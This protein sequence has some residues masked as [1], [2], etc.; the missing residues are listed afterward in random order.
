[1]QI[2]P[3][4]LFYGLRLV[5]CHHPLLCY[6]AVSLFMHI[7]HFHISLH[8][9]PFR[10]YTCV[11]PTYMHLLGRLLVKEEMDISIEFETI[12]A[13]NSFIIT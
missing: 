6:I 8:P 2:H 3:Y 10:F 5:A 12:P 11:M 7:C 4:V 1:M 9:L 13:L